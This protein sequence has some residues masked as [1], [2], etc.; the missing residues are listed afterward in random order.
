MGF[1]SR[2]PVISYSMLFLDQ[3][4]PT[5]VNHIKHDALVKIHK[6]FYSLLDKDDKMTT[7]FLQIKIV[8][9]FCFI[10]YEQESYT[11][12]LILS[13]HKRN[14]LFSSLCK[15]EYCMHMVHPVSYFCS[16]HNALKFHA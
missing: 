1:I 6:S 4:C 13:I 12:A 5:S 7:Q 2:Q 8:F 14:S 16:N 15:A 11:D 10:D 9:F 3:Q